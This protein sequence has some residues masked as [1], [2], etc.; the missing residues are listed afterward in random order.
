M[1]KSDNKNYTVA[2]ESDGTIQ[3]TFT[4][5]KDE[6]L[7]NQVK[8]IED[9]GKEVEVPGFRKGNAPTDKVKEHLSNEKV[10]EKT[11]SLILPKM[12]AFALSEE[13]IRPS[14]Y[15]KFEVLSAT[16]NEDWQVRAIMCE[17]PSFEL[18]DYK[19]NI[20]GLLNASKIW[21]PDNKDDPEKSKEPARAEKEQ[22][23]IDYLL[24]NISLII[25]RILIEEE[26]NSRLSQLLARIE[27]LGLTLEGYL[28]SI[29]KTPQLLR[30]EYSKQSQEA[31]K[32]ELILEKVS[33]SENIKITDPE[34]DQAV[35][36]S[37]TDPTIQKNLNSPEQRNLI[38]TILARRKA[39]DFLLTLL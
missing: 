32:I 8:V 24:Q 16:E 6:I 11:L 5:V 29:G 36:A 35:S 25:P 22:K 39:L 14:I 34:I 18:G 28:S 7:K 21:T 1:D 30:E 19:K 31:I 4:I 10:I 20:K 13:K 15:P 12:L 26:V 38:K 3:I 23:I 37:S 33:I 2:R 17:I 27:K 9:L